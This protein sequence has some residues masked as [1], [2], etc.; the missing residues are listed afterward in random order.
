M[1]CGGGA[2]GGVPGWLDRWCW[3]ALCSRRP[4]RLHTPVSPAR[5][6][7]ACAPCLAPPP[8]DPSLHSHPLGLAPRARQA[9]VIAADRYIGPRRA[10]PRPGDVCGCGCGV[11]LRLQRAG[12]GGVTSRPPAAR[13][14]ANALV[15]LHPLPYVCVGDKAVL[16]HGFRRLLKLYILHPTH[17]GAYPVF[18]S[19]LPAVGVASYHEVIMFFLQR[20]AYRWVPGYTSADTTPH[21][22]QSG[23]KRGSA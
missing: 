14:R 7:R 3:P 16:I 5:R 15:F 8:P 22:R 4:G 1:R 10:T 17:A 9:L 13:S 18:G 6:A 20:P 2:G 19:I 23:S 11:R 12:G 21:N